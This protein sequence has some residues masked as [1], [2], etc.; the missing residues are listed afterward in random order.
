MI[1]SELDAVDVTGED[2]IKA[3]TLSRANC[4]DDNAMIAT[5]R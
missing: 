1:S 5:I 3:D 2:E 4:D